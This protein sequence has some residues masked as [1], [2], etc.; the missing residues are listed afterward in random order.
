MWKDFNANPSGKRVGDYVVRAIAH[1]LDME[2]ERAY[3]DI[4]LQGFIDCDM[5]SA[6]E[7]WGAYLRRKGYKRGI[8]AE[9]CPTCYTVRDFCRDYP[10]GR[11]LL[12]LHEHVVSV[13]NGCYYDTWDSG[14]M[15][16]LYYWKK[17]DDE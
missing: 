10:E 3:T 11:Y 5:P 16:P 15:A 2:W 17:E 7:V 8:L 4:C 9:E 14:D 13:V 6:N 12:A 1:N